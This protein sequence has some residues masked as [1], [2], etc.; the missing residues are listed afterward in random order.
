VSLAQRAPRIT[1]GQHREIVR[2]AI[3]QLPQ[4]EI[5]ERVGVNRHTVR[6]VL[7]R[8]RSALAINEDLE[9]A[10]AEAVAV[11]RELQRSAW[12]KIEEGRAPAGLLGEIRQAQSRIDTL[13]GLAPGSAEDERAE[14]ERFKSI[15]MAT[16]AQEDPELSVRIGRRLLGG[17]EEAIDVTDE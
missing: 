7:N 15:V 9:S 6:R 17:T 3:R 16:L 2:L 14:L 1:E 8:V 4:T 10:R 12:E 13:L 5:A 11:Y